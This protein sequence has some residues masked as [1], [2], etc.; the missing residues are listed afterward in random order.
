MPATIPIV[1]LKK[2][3]IRSSDEAERAG[4]GG[5]GAGLLIQVLSP[6]LVTSQAVR[7]C[8]SNLVGGRGSAVERVQNLNCGERQNLECL[9]FYRGRSSVRP[10]FY[11]PIAAFHKVFSV[12]FQVFR[13]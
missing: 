12:Q 9:L 4:G 1:L 5:A 10:L 6:A 3:Q 7:L 8:Y 11:S 2:R 13:C